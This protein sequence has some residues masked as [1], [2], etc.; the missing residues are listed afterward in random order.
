MNAGEFLLNVKD[1]IVK[2]LRSVD[3]KYFDFEHPF[4]LD[5][6]GKGVRT[7]YCYYLAKTVGLD[8]KK[9][10]RVACA[11]EI[12]HLASLL[13]DDCIDD[14]KT[15]RGYATVN[16]TFGVSVA[17]LVGDIIA[18][19]AFERTKSL[20]AEVCYSLIDSV[21]RMTEGALF[22]ERVKFKIIDLEEYKQMVMLKTSE[23]FRWIGN[24]VVFLAGLD[25]FS[26]IERIAKNFGLS[27]QIIDDLIDIE[28]DAGF[29]G[30][31]T[32]KDIVEG[33]LNYPIIVAMED[34]NF[35]RMVLEYFSER[36]SLILAKIREYLKGNGVSK[37][38]REEAIALV[39]EIKDDVMALG[40]KE[41]ACDFYNYLYSLAQRRR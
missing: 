11:A 9:A 3:K 24:S 21:K 12:I 14:G 6:I 28:E 20:S 37:K 15:R 30:K 33:K 5:P 13:H 26:N 35:K 10:L 36:D 27:F 39:D 19:F 17:V 22:E 31:D 34:E 41:Y 25:K 32:F 8:L 4:F 18:Y 38:V 29:V 7:L 1:D 2:C 40:E 16:T 23:L